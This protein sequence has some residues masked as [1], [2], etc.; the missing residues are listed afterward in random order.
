MSQH[1]GGGGNI[2][3]AA[4]EMD[5]GQEFCQASYSTQDKPH[6]KIAQNVNS[7]EVKKPCSKGSQMLCKK[8]YFP[9]TAMLGGSPH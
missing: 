6:N 9:Q 8:S 7:A 2:L 1:G 5:K 4:N 3:Q